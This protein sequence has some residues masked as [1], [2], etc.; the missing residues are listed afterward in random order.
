MSGGVY[1]LPVM[2]TALHTSD[3]GRRILDQIRHIGP[4][5]QGSLCTSLKRCGRKSCRC[6]SEGPIHTTTLLTWKEGSDNRTRTL[7]IPAHLRDEVQTWLDEGKRLR[8]LIADM[9]AA[10]R[11]FLKTLRTTSSR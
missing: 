8:Q 11:D 3:E 10:Q 7:H 2:S 9:S 6:A 5:L 1:I 4:F